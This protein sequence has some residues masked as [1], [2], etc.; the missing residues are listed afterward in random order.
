LQHN[1]SEDYLKIKLVPIHVMKAC[2]GGGSIVPV[3]LNLGTRS[4]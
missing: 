2:R 1:Y 3:I 4:I